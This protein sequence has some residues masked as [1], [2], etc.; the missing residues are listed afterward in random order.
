MTRMHCKRCEHTC[1]CIGLICDILVLAA[2][3]GVGYSATIRYKYRY[4][5]EVPEQAL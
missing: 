3:G 5:E 2:Q 1:V 4:G